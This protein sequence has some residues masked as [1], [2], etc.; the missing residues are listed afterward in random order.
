[1]ATTRQDT[2]GRAADDS[3]QRDPDTVRED[4]ATIDPDPKTLWVDDARAW[5]E[6]LQ[7]APDIFAEPCDE[8]G[9]VSPADLRPHP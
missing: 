9:L 4:G 6:E 1:M 8:D 3:W 2:K 5:D 7:T